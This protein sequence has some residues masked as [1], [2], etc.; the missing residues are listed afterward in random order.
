MLT[1]ADGGGEGTNHWYT[2]VLT[3]GRNREVRRLFEALGVMVSRLT[4]TRYGII[5][6]PPQLK[7]GQTA[8]LERADLNALLKAAGLPSLDGGD[9][10]R[11][12]ER[13][14][15]VDPDAQPN[16][17]MESEAVS[18]VDG[19]RG[20][21]GVPAELHDDE[22]DE[23]DGNRAPP[24]QHQP[25]ARATG[26]SPA[27]QA[28]ARPAAGTTAGSTQPRADAAMRRS[29]RIRPSRRMRRAPPMP[30]ASAGLPARAGPGTAPQ[31]V[32]REVGRPKGTVKGMARV[33]VRVRVRARDGA[34]ADAA[35]AVVDATGPARVNPRSCRQQRRAQ[36]G[37]CVSNLGGRL[38]MNARM[39][40]AKSSR[41]AHA[42]KLA[43]SPE[44]WAES[45]RRID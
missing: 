28:E 15:M 5:S 20:T 6:L 18:E 19:N 13:D 34:D 23:V 21:Y 12:D 9:A 14:S 3:E 16:F 2:V 10:G 42:P 24:V 30:R 31:L 39:P 1:L 11:S 36:R 4:R 27:T 8:E 32:G 25:A 40:S 44:S 41:E 45:E 29:S 22:L 26:R 17:A 38:S 43:A 37:Y 7:R 35:V 33:R